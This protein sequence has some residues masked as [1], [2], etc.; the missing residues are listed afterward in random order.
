MLLPCSL[1]RLS[2]LAT[3]AGRPVIQF[4]TEH[5]GMIVSRSSS[6]NFRM[7]ASLTSMVSEWPLATAMVI[8]LSFNIISSRLCAGL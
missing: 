8:P 7:I 5:E 1:T 6:K 4:D 2:Q 3:S